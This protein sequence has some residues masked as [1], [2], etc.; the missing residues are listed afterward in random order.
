M[1]TT[2]IS[3]DRLSPLLDELKNNDK[4]KKLESTTRNGESTTRNGTKNGT[5]NTT[6]EAYYRNP[7][8]AE[9]RNNP[10]GKVL[11]CKNFLRG[12]FLILF[13]LYLVPMWIGFVCLVF[14]GFRINTP[15]PYKAGYG[16]ADLLKKDNDTLLLK[17]GEILE[18][19][20]VSPVDNSTEWFW[21]KSNVVFIYVILFS[22]LCTLY[23]TKGGGS[24]PANQTPIDENLLA[25]EE[26]NV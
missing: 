7:F 21:Q 20:S 8:W 1:S 17:K 6:R 12:T 18:Q 26:E 24:N 23:Y 10:E 2:I 5:L 4:L 16:G 11:T 15:N 14:N 22:T 3:D 13:L 25:R 9:L 19:E